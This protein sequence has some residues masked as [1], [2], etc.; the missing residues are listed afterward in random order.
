MK[1][2]VLDLEVPDLSLRTLL[3]DAAAVALTG[4]SAVNSIAEEIYNPLE[5]EDR[6]AR[7]EEEADQGWPRECQRVAERVDR[8][9]VQG[10]SDIS[11]EFD[12]AL[13]DYHRRIMRTGL[14]GHSDEDS[15]E[16]LINKIPSVSESK[17]EA[18]ER[19]AAAPVVNAPFVKLREQ[20]LCDNAAARK[21]Y[22]LKSDQSSPAKTKQHVLHTSLNGLAGLSVGFAVA[23]V[24]SIVWRLV[25]GRKRPQR[26][27]PP[28][29][30]GLVASTTLRQPSDASS[31]AAKSAAPRPR[32]RSKR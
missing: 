11:S 4:I 7:E 13:W 9:E 29:S 24:A 12:D 16:Y 19:Y 18:W 32:T 14:V 30:Q 27:Q 28:R 26:K 15:D 5:V 8:G 25:L 6:I 23:K 3:P 21:Q 10:S 2:P 22:G 20:A 17:L 31:A 1:I